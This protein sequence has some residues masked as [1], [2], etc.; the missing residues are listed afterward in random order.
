MEFLGTAYVSVC[1]MLVAREAAVVSNCRVF[2]L[3]Y[4]CLVLHRYV[5]VCEFPCFWNSDDFI[6]IGTCWFQLA[7]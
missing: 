4:R 6:F 5:N 1:F 2:P 7:I 3:P